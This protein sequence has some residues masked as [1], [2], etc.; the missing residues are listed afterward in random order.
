MI[1]PKRRMT[2]MCADRSKSGEAVRNDLGLC[3][4]RMMPH[5]ETLAEGGGRILPGGRTDM[6]PTFRMNDGSRF[7]T[8]WS[9]V[10]DVEGPLDLVLYSGEDMLSIRFGGSCGFDPQDEDLV[11]NTPLRLLKDA[12]E[13]VA[14]FD[15]ESRGITAEML[16]RTR[17]IAAHRHEIIMSGV[18]ADGYALRRS[19]SMMTK[20]RWGLG[21][22]F[23]TPW[24]EARIDRD[25]LDDD[26]ADA[27][28]RPLTGMIPIVV[29]A[30]STSWIS[31]TVKDGRGVD[32]VLKA[33]HAP[34][35]DIDVFALDPLDRMRLL[36]LADEMG[37]RR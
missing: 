15:A 30:T 33:A 24:S 27:L 22:T 3:V 36:S 28:D 34:S 37:L 1:D 21:M 35:A 31:G 32:A 5:A 8:T 20:G 25:G 6:P 11:R 4:S 2:A 9:V 16:D 23:A 18:Q 14:A 10:R 19:V 26:Y 7:Q 12:Q 17:A 13:L 29:D